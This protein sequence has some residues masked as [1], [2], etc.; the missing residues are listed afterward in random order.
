[1]TDL[2]S[3]A[4]GPSYI[5]ANYC[6][7]TVSGYYYACPVMTIAAYSYVATPVSVDSS[8]ST[9]YTMSTGGILSD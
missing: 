6:N 2:T 3:T 9:T 1:M 4:N 8:G 5:T 7:S